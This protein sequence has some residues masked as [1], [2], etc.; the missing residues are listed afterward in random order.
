MTEYQSFWLGSLTIMG[1]II[2]PPLFINAS[3]LITAFKLIT[4]IQKIF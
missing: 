3:L 4:L 2:N 1:V